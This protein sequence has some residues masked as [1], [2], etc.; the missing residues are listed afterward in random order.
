MPL[1]LPLPPEPTVSRSSTSTSVSP[2]STSARA[3]LRPAT[4]P[5][6]TTT[7][8]VRGEITA[9]SGGPARDPTGAGQRDTGHGGGLH[10][11][12]SEILRLEVV[13]A[14]LPAG[15]GQRGHLHGECA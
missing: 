10:R 2:S 13:H 4:P 12:R 14:G 1:D 6:I 11:Q 9:P 7:S 5:P 15:A 8:A 3:V